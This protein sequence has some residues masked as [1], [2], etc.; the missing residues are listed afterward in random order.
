MSLV[1]QVVVGAVDPFVWSTAAVL[2][3][4]AL[5]WAWIGHLLAKALSEESFRRAALVLIALMG[6]SALASVVLG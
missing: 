2:L 5:A 1:T 3:P 6:A 4:V